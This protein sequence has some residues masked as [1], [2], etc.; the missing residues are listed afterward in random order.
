MNYERSCGGVLFTVK[1]GVPYYVLVEENYYGFPKGHMEPGETERK[2]ALREI[3][4]EAGVDAAII[5]DFRKVDHYTLK[6]KPDTEKTVVY[7]L[8]YY[9]DQEIVY[10]EE[11]LNGAVLVPF[12]EA[13]KL[14]T[15]VRLKRV[16]REANRAA[17]RWIEKQQRK[18]AIEEQKNTS[19][20]D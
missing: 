17:L 12:P 2:T 18:K 15:H 5:G 16:L 10:Q 19:D 14:V 11:E 20:N 1:D 13:M 3:R 6:H 8:A 4:E 9:E 7:F